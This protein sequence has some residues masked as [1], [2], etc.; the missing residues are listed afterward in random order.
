MRRVAAIIV[1]AGTG[2]RFGSVKQFVSLRG[3]PVV[4]WCLE[5]FNA[6]PL[7]SDIVL[8]LPAAEVGEG[9]GR[10]F[11]RIRAVVEGGPERQDSVWNGFA[12]VAARGA[13]IVLVHDGVRPLVSADL[14]S[15]VIEAAA[16]T[17]AAVPGLALEDTI[18]EFAGTRIRRT[19]DRTGLVRV[20]TPQGFSFAVLKEALETARRESFLGT[21]EAML[22]ERLGRPV[23]LVQGEARNIKVTTPLDLKA[24]E[25]FLGE[26]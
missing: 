22:V 18:K 1:A 13:D 24:A 2:R 3:R 6:H 7:V 21:D 11:S 17:G 9:L 16:E 26:T 20:Q 5:A 15:R 25:A 12:R 10:S 23:M 19:L 8:V 4:D 14:I